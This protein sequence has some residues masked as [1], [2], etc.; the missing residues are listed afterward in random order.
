M[1]AVQQKTNINHGGAGAGGTRSTP[2]GR[3]QSVYGIGST[4]SLD[5]RFN[6]TRSKH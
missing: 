4:T 1:N 6:T 5:S 3:Q 2:H